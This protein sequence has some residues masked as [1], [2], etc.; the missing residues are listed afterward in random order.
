MLQTE[1][2]TNQQSL[3]EESN[4][5][6][7]YNNCHQSLSVRVGMTTLGSLKIFAFTTLYCYSGWSR[8]LQV[9]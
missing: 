1:K 5:L 8:I 3:T 7:Y 9:I 6:Q 2:E 4:Y